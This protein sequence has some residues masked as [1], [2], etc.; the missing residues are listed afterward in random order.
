MALRTLDE[1]NT[2][3]TSVQAAITATETAQSYKDALGQEKMMAH[4]QTLYKREN[5]LLVERQQLS[6]KGSSAG[7]AIV[8]GR[9]KR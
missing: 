7:L 9:R 6:S 8:H 1:I 5:D 2:A 4:L 3:L